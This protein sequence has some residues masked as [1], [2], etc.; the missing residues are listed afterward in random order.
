MTCD[1]RA[2][3]RS[4][5]PFVQP[6]VSD[7]IGIILSVHTKTVHFPLKTFIFNSNE[8]FP[9]MKQP[10]WS[11]LTNY[12]HPKTINIVKEP[13]NKQTNKKP[14]TKHR[15]RCWRAW[16][17]CCGKCCV[18]VYLFESSVL[19]HLWSCSNICL[20]RHWVWSVLCCRTKYSALMEKYS[21][22]CL[23]R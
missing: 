5:L 7:S 12:A 4:V 16:C 3:L 13:P 8:N 18:C 21:T 15:E 20:W 17:F 6:G 10:L 14:P 9:Q 1:L 23:P 2:G 19:K 22:A 11:P